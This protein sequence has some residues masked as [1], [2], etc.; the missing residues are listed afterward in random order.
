MD[1]FIKHNQ[2]DPEQDCNQEGEL[3]QGNGHTDPYMDKTV[4]SLPR[5]SRGTLAH[6]KLFQICFIRKTKQNKK[7][8]S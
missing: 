1:A 2:E 7:N 5:K 4:V 6:I 8:L 3:T